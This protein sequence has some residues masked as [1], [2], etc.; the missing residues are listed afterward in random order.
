MNHRYAVLTLLF[1]LSAALAPGQPL[2]AFSYDNTASAQKHWQPAFG[3]LPA[4]VEKTED[5]G[6]CIALDAEF[7]KVG[8]RGCWDWT[9]PVDLSEVGTVSFEVQATDGG[10][11]GNIGVYFG[12]PNGWYTKFWWGGV[13]DSWTPRTFRLDTFATEGEPD[14]WDKVTTFRFSMWSTGKGKTT[15]RLRNFRAHPI[16]RAENFVINGSFEIPGPGVP[17]GW[18]DGHWGVGGLPWV[19]NMDLWRKHWHLDSQVAKHGKTSLCIENTPDLPLLKANSVWLKIPKTVKFC[20]LS[21]WLK[22]DREALDV[23]L[24]CAGKSTK[25]TIGDTWQHVVLKGV[26]W[27]SRMTAL[28][29]PKAPGKLWIDAVQVQGCA[30]PT[31]EYHAA[32]RD[33]GIAARETLVDWSTPRRATTMAAKRSVSGP[34]T[35]ATV[36]I[37]E[38]GRFLLDGKPYI[39]HSLGLEFVSNLNVLNATAQSGFKDVCIQ[40]RESITT[41]QLKAIFDR[42]AQVGLRVIP[43]LDGRMSRER[44]SE[45]ITTLK[46]HPA[47]LCWYVYDEPSG[48]R[49]AEADARVK[50]AKSL[51]PG[52]PALIN[53]LG[54]RLENQTGDIYSTD[55]YPI[56]HSAPNTA[57]GGVRR[58]KAAAAAESKPVWMWLQGTGYAYWMD[59]EPSPRELSCMAYGSLIRGARGIYYFAQF[60]R[61]AECFDEM[62]AL[63]VEVDALAPALSS[64]ETGPRTTCNKPAIL[65]GTYWLD[66]VPWVLAVNT[67]AVPCK[68]RFE[69]ENAPKGG[70]EVL[71]EA[72]KV[73]IT[74]ATWEDAFGPYERHVYRLPRVVPPGA[75]Q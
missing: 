34:V 19:A 9:A 36:S 62:R 17:Y 70:A 55:I 71:F 43:W 27:H 67:Q 25:A 20:T 75:N 21:A 47:L 48:K 38:H 61:T 37:D 22:S 10:L 33:E 7:T 15:Y 24:Q 50:L 8:D 13:P 4:R 11:G 69:I 23:V 51:D 6:T 54:N 41:A 46:D 40:I 64:L 63:C 68:A 35:K 65:T 66:G 45:H 26:P 2:G 12:T 42:C 73:G 56:P 60:P 5:G 30:I 53:Y 39:Q 52:H 44:F 57:I 1:A 59:R 3:S 58:M 18:G 72:R 49:F 74:G 29:A 16:D 32:V 14:G 31:A 28:I